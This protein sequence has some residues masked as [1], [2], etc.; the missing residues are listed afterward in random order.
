MPVPR[1]KPIKPIQAFRSPAAMRMTMRRGQPKNTRAPIIM[2]KPSAK[3]TMGEE[4]AVERYSLVAMAIRKA[5]TTMPTISGRKY[6]TGSA[7]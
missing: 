6:C 5:P 2:M 3:R 7:E 4:P 1:T